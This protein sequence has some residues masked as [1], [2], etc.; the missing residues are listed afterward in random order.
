MSL[1]DL[2]KIRKENHLTQADVALLLGV[3]QQSVTAYETGTR[4][5]SPKVA[6]KI[7]D[8]YHLDIKDVWE[9]FYGSAAEEEE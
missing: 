2:K 9:M 6:G 5:P 3:K 7:A 1:I 8:L 4:T